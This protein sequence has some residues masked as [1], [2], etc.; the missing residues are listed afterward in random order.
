MYSVGNGALQ[1]YTEAA[2][3]YRKAADRDNAKAQYMLG[4]MYAIGRGVPR[5]DLRG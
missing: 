4:I 2:K 1:D 3:W 5:D